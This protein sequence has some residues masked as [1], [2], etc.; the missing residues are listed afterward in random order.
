MPINL[1]NHSRRT[2][3]VAPFD[4]CEAFVSG[5][6]PDGTRLLITV[7]PYLPGDPNWSLDPEL[8]IADLS[9]Q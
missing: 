8:W 4:T 9:E 5:M 1:R 7:T 2:W 3:K 6:S